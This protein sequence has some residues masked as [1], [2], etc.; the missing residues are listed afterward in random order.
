MSCDEDI[1]FDEDDDEERGS[2]SSPGSAIMGEL[3][4]GAG[5]SLGKVKL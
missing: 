1:S 2:P 5:K 3:F 4:E